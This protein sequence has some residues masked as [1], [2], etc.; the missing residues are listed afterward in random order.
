MK[1]KMT[2]HIVTTLH[3]LLTTYPRA[4][5]MGGGDR[6]KWNVSAVLNAV[7][8]LQNLQ[9]LPTLN[10]KNLDIFISNL[11]QFYSKSVV[12]APLQ[13]D[14]PSKG[15]P[16]DHSVP[17][18]YPLDNHTIRET[19]E[20]RERTTR[21]LPD[22]AVRA[23]GVRIIQE[24]WEDVKEDD[25]ATEQD[26]ALQKLLTE[27]LDELC[28]TK[29]VRLRM[30]DKPYI[31][32]ELKILDRQRKREYIKHGKSARYLSINERYR[33]KLETAASDY[34]NKNVRAISESEPGRAYSI[35]KRLGAQPGDSPDAG[36][37]QIKEH[38]KLGLTAAQSADRIAQKFAQI[39]QEYPP[40]Y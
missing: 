1:S 21:P 32:K 11:G 25:S 40:E 22:S 12:V 7:P 18:L 39:S 20:Y 24:D 28:P 6:N 31:T 19:E 3:Q 26:K 36:C 37:F 8:K 17:I 5:I 23:F 29:T 15:K 16:S 14:D 30:S 10:G 13:P 33:Q 38:S 2:D 27:M 34:L 4:G 9:M 35:L